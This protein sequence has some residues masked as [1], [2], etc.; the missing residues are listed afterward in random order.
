MHHI[1]EPV[2]PTNCEQRI[3]Q[4]PQSIHST[5]REQGDGAMKHCRFFET[6]VI[7]RLFGK[8]YC[9]DVEDICWWLNE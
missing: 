7:V 1:D 5:Q 4:V 9:I 8:E 6:C 2:Q 3:H